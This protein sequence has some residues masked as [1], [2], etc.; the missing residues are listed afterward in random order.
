M[1]YPYLMICDRSY[2]HK[3][4]KITDLNDRDRPQQVQQMKA[5]PPKSLPFGELQ[6]R[7][8]ESPP[9]RKQGHRS[10]C[11]PQEAHDTHIIVATSFNHN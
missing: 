2:L 10:E 7:L 11:D 9:D 6:A 8:D 1:N 5:I 4:S 3:L